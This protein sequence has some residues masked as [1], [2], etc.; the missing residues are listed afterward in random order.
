MDQVSPSASDN[1]RRV[2]ERNV[3]N[4]LC[5]ESAD[6]AARRVRESVGY[7]PPFTDSSWWIS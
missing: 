3:D 7:A 1:R 4:S 2:R 5:E 6:Y